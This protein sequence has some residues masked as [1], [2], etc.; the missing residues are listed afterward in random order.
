MPSSGLEEL[1]AGCGEHDE[2]LLGSIKG[3]GLT[4]C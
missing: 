2:M 1:V 3:E 4:D